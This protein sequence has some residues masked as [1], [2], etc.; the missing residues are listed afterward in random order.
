MT[1]TMAPIG[2]KLMIHKVTGKDELRGRLA[3]M[4]FVEGANV[5]VVNELN[6]NVIINVKETRVALDKSL[7]NRILVEEKRG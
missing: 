7:S 5:Y 1:L 4:G 2:K 6:G 3:T